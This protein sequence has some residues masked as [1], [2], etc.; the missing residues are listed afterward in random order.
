MLQCRTKISKVPFFLVNRT[1]MLSE[2]YV[3]QYRRT[4]LVGLSQSMR[5]DAATALEEMFA[6][7]K[8]NGIRLSTVSGYRSYTKQNT[9]YHRMVANAGTEA[10]NSLVARPGSSEHQLGLAMDIAKEG[11]SS[12]NSALHQQKKENGLTQTHICMVL[13]YDTKRYGRNYRIFL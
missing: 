4:N 3:P 5:D 12:L 6:D 1:E 2:K 8:A 11:S 9:I 13:S 10:A 7:A